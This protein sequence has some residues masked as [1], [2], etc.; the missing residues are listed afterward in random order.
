M[1]MI[2]H[3][4][5]L[6]DSTSY[7]SQQSRLLP[8]GVFDYC[9][10]LLRLGRVLKECDALVGESFIPWMNLGDSQDPSDWICLG[11]RLV[12]LTHPTPASTVLGKTFDEED[13]DDN[14]RRSQWR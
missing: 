3:R 5:N 1:G 14:E 9:S 6:Y 12:V 10:L 8:V 4:Q 7:D 2:P 11:T 13:D